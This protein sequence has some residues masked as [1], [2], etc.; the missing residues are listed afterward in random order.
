[1]IERLVRGSPDRLADGGSLVLV[2]QRRFPLSALMKSIFE[3]VD[4]LIDAGPHRV[5][6]GKK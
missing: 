4:V 3:V 1:M 6:L 5:W 2:T